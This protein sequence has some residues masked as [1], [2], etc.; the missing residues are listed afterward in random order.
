MFSALP[1]YCVVVKS[2]V[3]ILKLLRGH[4]CGD[5]VIVFTTDRRGCD[6]N[7]DGADCDWNYKAEQVG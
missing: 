6:L 4:V 2:L 7:H 1:T 5:L 3:V